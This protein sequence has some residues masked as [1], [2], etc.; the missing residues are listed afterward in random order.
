[1]SRSALLLLAL[2]ASTLYGAADDEFEVWVRSHGGRVERDAAGSLQAVS[3]S[4]SWITDPDLARI[5]ALGG[6]ESLDLSQTRI[7]DV[8]LEQLADL[9]GVR[10]LDLRFAEFVSDY[11]VAHLA[12]WDELEELDL[13]GTE[14]QS[15][16]FEHLAKL[17]SLR[18][19]D[20]SHTRVTDEGCDELA[21]L[22][23]LEEL[24]I[25][26][27]R[28][29]GGCLIS[30]RLLPTLKSLSVAGVQ[31]V[32][33]GIWGLALNAVNLERLGALN[34]LER[35]DLGGAT[36]TDIGS[37]KPGLP[38]AERKELGDLDLLAGLVDLRE[39][40]LSRQP[41]AAAELAVVAGF[42]KLRR[43]NLS[44]ATRLGDEIV[45]IVNELPDLESLYLSGTAL[46]DDGLQAL[47]GRESL[48]AVSVGA[49][50]VTAAG[51]QEFQKRRPQVAV[52]WFES[53]WFRETRTAQ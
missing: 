23:R 31:R 6:L 44:Q 13:R 51:V 34:G 38:D 11:G 3:L 7:T 39:L 27:N 10:K 29:N 2:T 49:T 52:T 41:V 48:R 14:I 15:R 28:L 4:G 19:L 46:S 35:L 42:K 17:V 43:L 36:I 47:A 18:R 9:D 12:E 20:I 22:E 33:S 26:S 45:E 30:L 16:V 25:G 21:K 24:S 5:S 37:D 32:D 8:G 40:D 53:D 50:E 1:M